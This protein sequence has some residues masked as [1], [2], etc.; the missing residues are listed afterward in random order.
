M[1]AVPCDMVAQGRRAC[2][3]TERY[4]ELEWLEDP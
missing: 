3:M 1:G 4:E 2:E